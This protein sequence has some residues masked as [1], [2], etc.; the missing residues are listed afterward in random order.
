MTREEYKAT[1]G[2]DPVV[3]SA[4]KLDIT[5]APVQMTMAEYQQ[6]YGGIKT[7]QGKVSR[8]FSTLNPLKLF[9]PKTGFKVATDV[10]NDIKEVFTGMWESAKET[11]GDINEAKRDYQSGKISLG[12]A[13]TKTAGQSLFGMADILIGQPFMGAVKLPFT[14]K[15]EDEMGQI[16]GEAGAEAFDFA[17]ENYR[18]KVSEWRVGNDAEQATASFLDNVEKKYKTDPNFKAYVDG[19]GGAG[20]ALAD[21]MTFRVGGKVAKEGFKH[22]ADIAQRS[23]SL[24]NSIKKNL[25]PSGD[26]KVAN[27]AKEIDNIESK[28]VTT[29]KARSFEKDEGVASR[30]RIAESNVLNEAIDDD[31]LLQTKVKGGAYD[32][33]RDRYVKPYE[34]VVRDYLKVENKTISLAE[35]ENALKASVG[36]SG[37][38]GGDLVRALKGIKSEVSGLRMWADELDQIPLYKIHDAKIGET[39]HINFNTP[40]ETA[41]YRKAKARTYKELVEDRSDFDVKSINAE[42][43]KYY[44]DLERLERLDGKRVKGARLGK[45]TS[46]IAGNIAGGA[47]GSVGGPAGMAA[48]AIVGGEVASMLKGVGMKRTLRGKDVPLKRNEVLEQAKKAGKTAKEMDL[49]KPDKPLGAPKDVP[50]TPEIRAVE[51]QIRNNVK[52]QKAAIKASDFA[53]VQALKEVYVT[54]VEKLRV[55]VRTVR[56][57]IDSKGG[58]Q[59]GFIKNP[60]VR[61]DVKSV[62]ASR[63][64]GRNIM[65]EAKKALKDNPKGDPSA[66]EL[67]SGY[68]AGK[69]T[70]AT[71]TE[72]ATAIDMLAGK[73]KVT[74]A[75]QTGAI[76]LSK[77]QQGTLAAVHNLTQDKIAFADEIGGL[78]NPSV[79]VVKP[80]LNDFEN[81]GDITMIADKDFLFSG[82]GKTFGADVYSPRFPQVETYATDYDL[83]QDTMKKYVGDKYMDDGDFYRVAKNS[84][85][86]E[87]AFEKNLKLP[88]RERI[89]EFDLFIE[90]VAEE[91]GL[92]KRIFDGF[93]PSGKRRYVKV[94]AESVSKLMSKKADRGGET[95]FYGLPSIRSMVAPQFRSTQ[96]IKRAEDRIVSSESFT[97]VKESY[98]KQLSELLDDLQRHYKYESESFGSY[99]DIGRGLG[100][101][102]SGRTGVLDELFDNL[103]SEMKE[104]IDKFGMDLAAMPTE[105]FETKFKRVVDLDEFSHAVIPSDTPKSVKDVLKRKGVAYTEYKRGKGN[106]T[107]AL[108]QALLEK[109]LL[110]G[111]GAFVYT[112]T[113]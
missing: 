39:K 7:G 113:K 56:D 35:V 107:E 23:Q 71:R 111:L 54:L 11:A 106:Q 50:K 62:K 92:K 22:S 61:D 86:F 13:T 45:Y 58:S 16:I 99:D 94:D 51:K 14:Q 27:V 18:S 12:A 1:Y 69:D 46:Q 59:A 38:V 49:K 72:L 96:A 78:A 37:L 29:R 97:A 73:K 52:Q 24:T 32:T 84:P 66:R 79:A 4:S 3:P 109:G 57:D 80:T 60:I 40:A 8:T 21:F 41:T 26:K 77:K 104:R 55:M 36:T 17:G 65:S 68:V 88:K 98:E 43:K 90:G 20:F 31:G 30:N 10:P 33:Y 6:R 87:D 48:G 5:P 89:E 108:R 28:Y 82:K 112:E 53:L 93:T 64:Q 76:E 67:L 95:A 85:E 105:Y 44:E 103:P 100:E 110:F 2:A 83:F 63:P 42:L 70:Q 75:P 9:N 34:S 102:Y 25:T 15:Q 74:K 101:Y 19:V 47:M 81:F 91:A